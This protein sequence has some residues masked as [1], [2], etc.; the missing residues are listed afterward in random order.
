MFENINRSKFWVWGLKFDPSKNSEKCVQLVYKQVFK[1]F[2]YVFYIQIHVCSTFQAELFFVFSLFD[3]ESA[4]FFYVLLDVLY[5]FNI[6]RYSALEKKPI[7][8]FLRSF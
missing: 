8:G 7:S 3:V 1:K 5:R 2:L 4:G 6:T